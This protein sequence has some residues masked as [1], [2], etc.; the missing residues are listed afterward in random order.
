[1]RPFLFT[2]LVLSVLAAPIAAQTATPLDPMTNDKVKSYDW[3][4]PEADYVRKE[5]MIPMRD[6]VK[7]F[8]VIV[9]RKGTRDA[10]MLL[11]RS[12]YDATG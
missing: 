2:G 10:P 12:P 4:R 8:T 5:V 3:V 7:L 11:S 1:M 6:G 9:Y